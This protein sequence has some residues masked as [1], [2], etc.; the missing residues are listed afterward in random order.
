M[1]R[2]PPLVFIEQGAHAL[3]FILR[4]EKATQVGIL[5]ARAFVHLRRF[6]LKNENLMMELK[7]NDQ[8]S[9]TFSNFKKRIEQNLIVLYKNNSKYEKKIKS[10]EKRLKA[11]EDKSD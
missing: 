2:T 1:K 10:I 9:R 6:V 8:L 4:S 11:L 3:S 5:I 7:N